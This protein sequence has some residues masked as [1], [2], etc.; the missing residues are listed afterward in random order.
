MAVNNLTN[1]HRPPII[2]AWVDQGIG[3]NGTYQSMKQRFEELSPL[4]EKWYYFVTPAEFYEFLDDK[5]KTQIFLIMSGQAG[6]QI[7]PAR[8]TYENIHSMYIY[9]GNVNEHRRL[10]EESDKVK[11]VMNL[12]DDVYERIADELSRLLLN[13]GESYVRSQ[14]RGLA[15]NYLT[16]ALRLMKTILRYNNNHGRVIQV[17]DLLESIDTS[18]EP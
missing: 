13:I 15:R 3:C 5:P 1:H 4:I 10:K 16:E 6:Q 8:H 7:V 12:E 2:G 18:I 9:C 11:D 14:D 17:N